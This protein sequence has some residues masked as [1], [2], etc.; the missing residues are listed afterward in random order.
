MATYSIFGAG[1]TSDNPVVVKVGCVPTAMVCWL[2]KISETSE[3]GIEMYRIEQYC[4][5]VKA[6]FCDCLEYVDSTTQGETTQETTEEGTAHGGQIKWKDPNDV[7]HTIFYELDKDCQ[8]GGVNPCSDVCSNIK[9]TTEPN[10]VEKG[11]T[12]NITVDYE[13]YITCENEVEVVNR[14]RYNGSME[15][16]YAS[17]TGAGSEKTYTFP[18]RSLC[19]EAVAKV[20]ELDVNPCVEG[21]RADIS[22]SFD[23]NTVPAT[24]ATVMVTI[25][26]IKTV[27]DKDCNKKKTSGYW[28]KSWPVTCE[29]TSDTDTHC[30]QDHYV[31]GTV[32]IDTIKAK[33]GNDAE[34][35]YNGAKV[36][37]DIEFSILQKA[38]RDGY[39]ENTCYEKTTYCVD[40]NTVKV[41]YETK[42]LS[43]EWVIEGGTTSD[44]CDCT[45][46]ELCA[47]VD[48]ENKCTKWENGSYSVPFTGGRIKVTW[49]YTAHTKTENCN[50]YD[51][52]GTWEEIIVIGGCDERPVDCKAEYNTIV[53]DSEGHTAHYDDT[54][55]TD[56]S[57]CDS[58]CCYNYDG[59]GSC[60]CVILFKEQTPGCDKCDSCTIYDTDIKDTITYNKIRYKFV[61]DC[62]PICEYTTVTTYEKQTLTINCNDVGDIPVEVPYTSTTEYIGV[63]CPPTEYVSGN[64]EVIVTVAGK[65]VTDKDVIAYDSD[66]VRIIQRAGGEGECVPHVRPDR[67]SCD[68]LELTTDS[69]TC[70]TEGD[71]DLILPATNDGEWHTIGNYESNCDG[72]WRIT[73]HRTGTNMLD[74]T[75]VKFEDGKIKAKIKLDNELETEVSGQYNTAVGECSDYFTVYQSPGSGGGGDDPK[76]DDCVTPLDNMGRVCNDSKQ[77]EQEFIDYHMSCP[78]GGTH[79][80]SGPIR[81]SDDTVIP[82]EGDAI[83]DSLRCDPDNVQIV[84]EAEWITFHVE[85]F[86]QPD[87]YGFKGMVHYAFA[88]NNDSA[89]RMGRVKVNL[90]SP[91]QSTHEWEG[92]SAGTYFCM[93]TEEGE[94]MYVYAYQRG[95]GE[96][97]PTELCTGE[98]KGLGG[99]RIPA[100]PGSNKVKIGTYTKTDACTSNWTATDK[101]WIT[102]IEF[103]PNGDIVANVAENEDDRE[104]NIRILTHLNGYGDDFFDVYQSGGSEPP[105]PPTDCTFEVRG[106]YS[107]R[108]FSS[109]GSSNLVKLA[110]IY[111][112]NDRCDCDDINASSIVPD[113]SSCSAGECSSINILYD[114][115]AVTEG[116]EC[117]VKAKV[118]PNHGGSG[119]V[120]QQDT[121]GKF[122][123]WHYKVG[124][125]D[126]CYF[127]FYQVVD[128]QPE[129]PSENC[130]DFDCFIERFND[131]LAEAPT[132]ITISQS[133]T[134]KIYAYLNSLYTEAY[135]QFYNVS[136][137][138]K[139]AYLYQED[140]PELDS[141]TKGLMYGTEED[142]LQAFNAMVGF[143]LA[144]GLTEILPTPGYSGLIYRAGYNMGTNNLTTRL[145]GKYTYHSNP[146]TARLIGSLIYAGLRGNTESYVTDTVAPMRQETGIYAN[147][148]LLIDPFYIITNTKSGCCDSSDCEE[149]PIPY[150]QYRHIDV[151]YIRTEFASDCWDNIIMTR[152]DLNSFFPMG[153]GPYGEG[154][155]NDPSRAFPNDT[156]STVNTDNLDV[157]FKIY[158]HIIENY[159]LDSS[160]ANSAR[161]AQATADKE[162]CGDH[163]FGTAHTVTVDG[164][165]YTINPVFN[166]GIDPSPEKTLREFAE[167]VAQIA[168]DQRY[169]GSRTPGRYRPGHFGT[170]CGGSYS[171]G[172]FLCNVAIDSGDG[173]PPK[174]YNELGQ[175][176]DLVV[177][178]GDICGT[179]YTNYCNNLAS[180]PSGHSGRM[181]ADALLLINLHPELVFDL[182]KEGYT[183]A[184]NRTVARFHW[185]SDTICGRLIGAMAYPIICSTY[186]FN[187][188][189]ASCLPWGY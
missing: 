64:T 46:L 12:G 71:H 43:N 155:R 5:T 175:L 26:Y 164:A 103:K 94:E 15:V 172:S 11:Y 173:C 156:R 118:K 154:N 121:S 29:R 170:G 115:T 48:S 52:K 139:L 87:A 182:A 2:V 1:S 81:P 140:M 153:P 122:E 13:Y 102:G 165:Q 68:Y 50:E 142:E 80:W 92:H 10:V 22:V 53:T 37:S 79:W 116:G 151:N 107:Y 126:G 147:N 6:T 141:Y 135:K 95:T 14:V 167:S 183:Y 104:R 9:T 28:I 61:Q 65:N 34:I 19:S 55:Y 136:E 168:Q 78:D 113:P 145:Y 91:E 44:K 42:Y 16:P 90:I 131:A 123:K 31:T 159:I 56:C 69:C 99:T 129:P 171:N 189:L 127:N 120:V 27:T 75:N 88:A 174:G 83:G 51:T 148:D 186:N 8:G 106:E 41:Y 152:E 7:E 108:R 132:A 24:G 178:N 144:M 17:F 21:T 184:V 72:E 63:G 77:A 188:L 134:P 166:H 133:S 66:M 86:P 161:T 109:A 23:M 96:E 62:T 185:T 111:N 149:N 125:C 82:Q 112:F 30:C 138:R 97:P 130:S 40:K 73:G 100:D 70:K 35:Y 187:G 105:G 128:D 177:A 157:D 160:C 137:G 25:S 38:K 181:W 76:P 47:E 163:I 67:C 45:P 32:D 150:N 98:T 169:G 180:F 60:K 146:M 93:G 124:N 4:D 3:C 158:Q 49:D 20:T 101:E 36:T 58:E 176:V 39:C 57:I 162:T 143:V 110:T 54:T 114:I 117:V 84:S 33:V 18:V 179:E 85:K 119:H 59:K 74:L 89:P